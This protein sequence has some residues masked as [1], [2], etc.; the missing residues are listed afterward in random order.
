VSACGLRVPGAGHVYVE[1]LGDAVAIHFGG[2]VHWRRAEDEY[3]AGQFDF[4]TLLQRIFQPV[5]ASREEV[6]LFARSKLL[7]CCR[8]RTLPHAAS[9]S[10]HQVIEAFPGGW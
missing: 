2:Y 7:T 1:D 10:F 6:A 9:E 4:A 5:R 8:D 3:L